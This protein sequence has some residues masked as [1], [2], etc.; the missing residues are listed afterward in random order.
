MTR[1]RKAIS[2]LLSVMMIL[3]SMPLAAL[4]AF[5]AE[6]DDYQPQRWEDEELIISEDGLWRYW[7]L[8]DDESIEICADRVDWESSGYFGEDETVVIPSEIDG[9]TV[10]QLGESTFDND[11][12]DYSFIKSIVI[13]DTV[14]YIGEYAFYYCS[15]LESVTIP[16]SVVW[17]DYSAFCGC[18][19]LE[20]IEIPDSVVYMGNEMFSDCS[21]LKYVTLSNSIDMLGDLFFCNCTSL[22]EVIIPKGVT[23]I[24]AAFQGCTSL[25]KVTIPA[26]VNYIGPNTFQECESLRNIEFDSE[27]ENYSYANGIIYNKDKTEIV[28]YLGAF[29]DATPEDAT[30]EEDRL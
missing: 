26:S 17:I 15:E 27:N 19:S 4:N 8:D 16:S 18:S 13:P 23:E 5:A 30:P 10:T 25:K 20:S 1:S 12:S 9:Y 7:I 21:S 6:D 29:Y 14:K 2:I 3:S 24:Y 11:Y 28:Y 22:E